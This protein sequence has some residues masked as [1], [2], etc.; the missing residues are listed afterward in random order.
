MFQ[1]IKEK[2]RKQQF[3]ALIC[4]ML[5]CT[6]ILFS[7]KKEKINHN[8]ETAIEQFNGELSGARI[9]D[10][11]GYDHLIAN[12]DSLTNFV[13]PL[14]PSDP[15]YKEN[16]YKFPGTKYFPYDGR[17]GNSW[18]SVE[19]VDGKVGSIW[20][21]PKTLFQSDR[22]INLQ[23]QNLDYGGNAYEKAVFS[24][25]LENN[26][27]VDFYVL[28]RAILNNRADYFAVE[29]E[30]KEPKSG[31]FKIRIIN[32]G[33]NLEPRSNFNG[34]FEDHYGDISLAYADGQLVS[35]AT[36]N[37]NP[38]KRVSDYVEIPYGTYQFKILSEKGREISGATGHV[39]NR[40]IDPPS[41]SLP[42][43]LF[44]PSYIVY[45]P[46]QTYQP[47]GIYTIVV[48]PFGCEFIKNELGFIDFQ[49]QNTFKIIV[50]KKPAVNTS[51]ARVQAVNALPEQRVSFRLNGSPFVANLAYATA[52][53]YQVKNTGKYQIEAVDQNGKVLAQLER[54]LDAKMNYTL[55]LYP[56]PE[57]PAKIVV[58]SNDL[59]GTIH[60]GA[61]EEDASFDYLQYA[62]PFS[63]RFINLC[64]DIPYLTITA[65]NGQVL[66]GTNDNPAVYN[67]QPG[68]APDH[69][70]YTWGDWKSKD[71]EILAYRSSP[72]VTPGTWAND[73][74]ILT[75]EN[76]I[77]RKE[78]YTSGA[79]TIPYHEPGIYTIAVIGRTGT[80][81]PAAAKAKMI[82]VKHNL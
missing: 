47:G 40:I 78:L 12:G 4:T 30:T 50:D 38:A 5:C 43:S 18:W 25:G 2:I 3:G 8:R 82:V 39:V 1:E 74:K 59:S 36:S 63:K 48:N 6:L 67:L 60:F 41:S 15:A 76:F 71:Y 65:K 19:N 57:G 29:R 10:L 9:I 55:W 69:F 45:A 14:H 64:P 42:R 24:I 34:P 80:N 7:C 61:S 31:H 21:I 32:F 20:D 49:V 51:F 28:N 79:K 46:I 73:I 58:T 68:Q 23:L 33:F 27:N 53:A 37:V 16:H 72:Q 44:D 62:M 70:P 17:M 35:G 54:A 52:S 81:V 66:G 11:Y 75:N 13:H 77:A 26:N 22:S 56:S